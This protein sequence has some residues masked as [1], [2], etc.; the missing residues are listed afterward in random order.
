MNSQT[1]QGGYAAMLP[2]YVAGRELRENCRNGA[3]LPSDK[4]ESQVALR[5]SEDDQELPLHGDHVWVRFNA[6]GYVLK[7]GIRRWQTPLPDEDNWYEGWVCITGAN[8]DDKKNERVFLPDEEDQKIPVDDRIKD[9]WREL[10]YDYQLEHKKDLEKREQE[11]KR[12][13][14]YSGRDPGGTAWSR[15]VYTLA[16]SELTAGTLCYV[17]LDMSGDVSGVQPVIISRRLFEEPPIELVDDSLKPAGEIADLSPADRVFGWVKQQGKGSYKGNL[18]IHGVTCESKNPIEDFPGEGLALAILGQPRPSQFRFY[19]SDNQDNPIS[20]PAEK[21]GGFNDDQTIRGRKVYPHHKEVTDNYWDN[22]TNRDERNYLQSKHLS[23]DK[24]RSNQNRSIKSWVKTNVDFAFTIDVTNLSTV[25]LG[26]LLWLLTLPPQDHF[27]RLGGGKPLGFGS[28]SVTLDDKRKTDLRTG[29]QWQNYYDS[30][31]PIEPPTCDIDEVIQEFKEAVKTAYESDFEATDF[32]K[33]FLVMAKGFED[34][35]PIHYPR[36]AREP[37]PK[38]EGF[39]WFVDNERS[40]KEGGQR[41]PLP[42]LNNEKGLPF[43]PKKK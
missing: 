18:R 11:H 8:I 30:L 38:G 16:D 39:K 25:E 1:L 12:P 7:D 43:N 19:N 41:L 10:I 9:L 28:V 17:E 31:L 40:G 27:H 37:D 33:A 6:K 14:E 36:V 20:P 42:V 35:L 26:A 5:Y 34:G 13:D 22:P 4:G 23:E 24:R 32:I 2:R 21:R 29:S 15:H 3:Q